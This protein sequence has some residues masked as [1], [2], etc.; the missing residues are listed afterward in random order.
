VSGLQKYLALLFLV[1]I[2]GFAGISAQTIR[3]ERGSIAYFDSL[4]QRVSDLQKQ[5]P[6]LKQARDVAYYNIQ[7]EL[8]LTLFVKNVE[9]YIHEEDLDNAKKVVEARLEK[10]E[11]RREQYSVT[12]CRKYKDD[13]NNLIKQQRIHYQALFAKEKNFKKEFD[14]LAET[15]STDN[16]HKTLRM[17][18]LALKYANENNLTETIKYLDNYKSYTEA[19]IFDAGS[20]YDLASLTGNAKE[21]EKVFLPLVESDTIEDIREAQSLISYCTNYSRLT[22]SRLD[23]AFFARQGLVVTSSLSDLLESKGREKELE[24]YTDEAVKARVDSLNPCGVFKWHDQIIV[25]DEFN[26]S[27]TMEAV[28]K[29]EAI[30]H[31]DKMLAAYLKKNKLCTSEKDLTF[32]YAF[33]I[34]YHSDAKNSAFFFNSSSQK[35]Q[36]ITCYTTVIDTEY[37]Q[38]VSKY[39]PPLLFRDEKDMAIN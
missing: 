13:V 16:Y 26:P 19:L 33:V 6:K 38:H 20:E 7:R 11:F 14:R 28:K 22:G 3:L 34:P 1:A 2:T 4:D 29:G 25:I 30:I 24:R 31:A 27:S 17:V 39:M 15:G 12:F 36:Y 10:A 23:P 9:E 37:T 5:I 18:N 32:G 35:W 8:E 21:F